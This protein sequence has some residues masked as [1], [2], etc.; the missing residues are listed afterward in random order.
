M[1]LLKQAFQSR[2]P[3]IF[4]FAGEALALMRDVSAI[5]LIAQACE[6]LPASDSVALAGMLA[7]YMSPELHGAWH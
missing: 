1:P 2:N 3:A 7:Y 4:G 6:R 5:P